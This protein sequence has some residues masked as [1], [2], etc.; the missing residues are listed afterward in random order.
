MKVSILWFLLTSSLGYDISSVRLNANSTGQQ[1]YITA[2]SYMYRLP[3]KSTLFLPVFGTTKLFWTL[4]KIAIVHKINIYPRLNLGF[5]I[6]N[7]IRNHFSK[8]SKFY[9]ILMIKVRQYSKFDMSKS[10]VSHVQLALVKLQ[11]I[12]TFEVWTSL[13]CC[14]VMIL[15][16]KN[17]IYVLYS[18][19]LLEKTGT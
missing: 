11:T 9:V 7:L 19:L 13:V 12:I 16:P 2:F 18:T 3:F 17:R 6:D 1:D 14:K 5:V 15:L 10:E 8:F 4:F